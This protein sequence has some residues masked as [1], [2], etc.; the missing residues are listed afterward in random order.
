MSNENR[1]V[2]TTDIDANRD[3]MTGAPGSHPVGTAAGA[4]AGGLAAG[5]AA[6]T[7]A[8]PVGTGVGAAVGAVV[9]GL[10]GKAIA[11]Q[12][13]PTARR[14][15]LARQLHDAVRTS[16]R[17]ELRRL[18]PGL[19]LRRELVLHVPRPRLRRSR[20]RPVDAMERAPRQVDADLGSRQARDPRRLEPR[21][22]RVERAVPGDS[23]RDGK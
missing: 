2:G 1:T 9:G 20:V 17:R 15:L 18:R 6:G 22:R 14:R 16:S 4:V 21:Q 19:F 11:E 12:I 7:V 23:D 13:D 5:A 3:P 10:A 8:G